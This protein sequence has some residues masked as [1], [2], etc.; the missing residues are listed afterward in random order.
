MKE[1]IRDLKD[2]TLKKSDLLFPSWN[3]V[4]T[5]AVPKRTNVEPLD[6]AL[7]TANEGTR[8]LAVSSTAK[9]RRIAEEPFSV[10]RHLEAPRIGRRRHQECFSHLAI[11]R[12]TY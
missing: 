3:T 5:L 4:N 6:D 1:L 12:G 8:F 7:E 10:P 2:W 9:I 11:H